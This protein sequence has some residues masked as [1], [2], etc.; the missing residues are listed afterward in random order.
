M[1]QSLDYFYDF[2]CL[3]PR[4]TQ[5][6]TFQ[7]GNSLFNVTNLMNGNRPNNRHINNTNT[8]NVFPNLTLTRHHV[9]PMNSLMAFFTVLNNLTTGNMSDQYRPLINRN[10]ITIADI[11]NEHANDVPLNHYSVSTPGTSG[12]GIISTNSITRSVQNIVNLNALTG[13]NVR[14]NVDQLLDNEL[15]FSTLVAWIPGNIFLGPAP[16]LRTDDPHEGFETN[17]SNIVGRERFRILSDLYSDMNSFGQIENQ[18]VSSLETIF[19]RIIELCRMNVIPFRSTDW[20]T[21]GNRFRINTNINPPM[22]KRAVEFK[23]L[24]KRD[25]KRSPKVFCE[26]MFLLFVINEISLQQN[27]NPDS[28]QETKCVEG[29]GTWDKIKKFL[30][31][32]KCDRIIHDELKKREINNPTQFEMVKV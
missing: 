32:S 11:Y 9:I 19:N 17:S 8:D 3:L 31:G 13:G 29:T 25:L 12:G 18:N 15:I 23:N 7:V 27:T 28:S 22:K 26:P 10:I 24:W 16:N 14:V 21:T 4:T 2:P 5:I 1:S 6:Q 20:I 30:A